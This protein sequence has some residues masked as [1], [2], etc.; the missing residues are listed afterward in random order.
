MAKNLIDSEMRSQ[1]EEAL[2]DVHETFAKEIKIFQRKTETFVATSTSTYNALYNRLKNEQKTLGKVTETSAQA[3]V[4]Y[5][6]TTEDSRL[7]GTSAQTNLILPDG[8]VRLKIDSD[9]YQKIKR[10]SKVEID[11]K[12]YELVSDSGFTGPFETKYHV[13]YLKRKD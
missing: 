5:I 2:D 11:E 6:N 1:I 8:S 3:R 9:G 7:S 10:A 12:L 13:L 4:E